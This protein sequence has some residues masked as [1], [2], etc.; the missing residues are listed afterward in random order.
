MGAAGQ[1]L[2]GRAETLVEIVDVGGDGHV[3]ERHQELAADADGD[4]DQVDPAEPEAEVA[5]QAAGSPRP[6]AS[7][8]AP[9]KPAHSPSRVDTM[10]QVGGSLSLVMAVR[11]WRFPVAAAPTEMA[12]TARI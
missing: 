12:T 11:S 6:D 9:K 7:Q 10:Y 1:A 5:D 4:T 2:A 8:P 3:D